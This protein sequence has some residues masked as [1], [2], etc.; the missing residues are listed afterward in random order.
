[1]NKID[2][3]HSGLKRFRPVLRPRRK[4]NILYIIIHLVFIA[5]QHFQH[6]RMIVAQRHRRYLRVHV[7]Q[8]VSIDVDQV[9]PQRFVVISE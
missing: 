6:V 4:Y 3:I 2:Q 9:V 1:M 8:Y 7:Q 5:V